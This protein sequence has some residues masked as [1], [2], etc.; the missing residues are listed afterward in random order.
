MWYDPPKAYALQHSQQPPSP[1]PYPPSSPSE[2]M[3]LPQPVN[4]T[5]FKGF[6]HFPHP[7]HPLRKCQ[8]HPHLIKRARLR[9][10]A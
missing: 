4:L 6:T 5:L 10:G 7:Q 2:A 8:Y 3:N 9:E 1:P